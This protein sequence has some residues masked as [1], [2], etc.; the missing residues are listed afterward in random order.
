MEKNE[1]VK[2]KLLSQI[3]YAVLEKNL[4]IRDLKDFVEDL[5]TFLVEDKIHES[6]RRSNIEK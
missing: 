2:Q 6:G 5:E 1:N 4:T 3:K